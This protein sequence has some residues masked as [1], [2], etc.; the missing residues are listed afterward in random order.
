LRSLGELDHYIQDVENFAAAPQAVRDGYDVVLFY[1]YHIPT[2]GDAERTG[3]LVR[4]ALERLGIAPQG[5]VVLHHALLSYPEWPAWQAL[6]GLHR[7]EFKYYEGEQVAV[8]IADPAPLITAGLRPWTMTDETYTLPEPMADSH[9]LL[10]TD[11]PRSMRTL[12]WVRPHGAARV[13]C[14]ESGHDALTYTD[15]NFM[16][17]L[18]RGIQWAAG[19][20]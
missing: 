12:A 2:P 11:N 10:S 6:I 4:S 9:A 14:L 16:Q 1:D 13:F 17:V 15:P 20:L 19:R 18:A 7:G 5:V 3:P 8:S